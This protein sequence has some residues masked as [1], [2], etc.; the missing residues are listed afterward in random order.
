MKSEQTSQMSKNIRLFQKNEKVTGD[1][2]SLTATWL[3]YGSVLWMSEP[4]TGSVP[5]LSSF[6]GTRALKKK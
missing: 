3:W 2:T 5:R 6:S 4:G 1:H